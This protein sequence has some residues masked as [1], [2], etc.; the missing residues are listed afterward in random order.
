MITNISIVSV[1]VKDID[2]SLRFYVDV[3]GFAPK[4]DVSLGDYLWST[5]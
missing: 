2:E 4:D 3:L 5:T 1:F